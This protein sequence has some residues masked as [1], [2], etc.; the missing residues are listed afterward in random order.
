MDGIPSVRNLTGCSMKILYLTFSVPVNMK[1][2]GGIRSEAI[3]TALC[4]QHEVVLALI[5]FEAV[6]PVEYCTKF[7]PLLPVQ[8]MFVLTPQ[9]G[10]VNIQRQAASLEGLIELVKPD[11]VW[12]FEK[13]VLRKTGFPKSVPTVLDLVS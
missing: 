4:S 11:L 2:G 3:F 10:F 5:P 1:Y 8:E 12:A 7:G 13:W 9:A 6:N